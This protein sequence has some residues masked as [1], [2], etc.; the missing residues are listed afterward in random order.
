MSDGFTVEP[1]TLRAH[2]G[3]VNEV[4]AA[5]GR[6]LPG[7]QALSSECYGMVG[8]AFA[9]AATS[10]MATGTAAVEEARR[11]LVGLS[12]GL[13]GA[14]AEYENAD[15]RAAAMFGGDR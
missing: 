9:G 8:Q 4:E 10:A 6:A 2:A 13:T 15:L 12:G 11:A 14:G 1:R 7:R 5:V 3:H